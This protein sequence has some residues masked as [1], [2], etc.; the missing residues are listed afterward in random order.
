MLPAMS[1]RRKWKGSP[2]R[3]GS[4]QVAEPV[5]HRL[6]GG[7]EDVGEQLHV[8]AGALH[9]LEEVAVAAA[10]ARRRSSWPG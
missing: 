4:R 2:G 9:L 10:S 8:V 6:V 7:A 3:L 5:R 1:A